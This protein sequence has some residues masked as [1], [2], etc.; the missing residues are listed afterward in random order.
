[1][2]QPNHLPKGPLG[3]IHIPEIKRR[4]LEG[5]LGPINILMCPHTAIT[6]LPAP[7]ETPEIGAASVMVGNLIQGNKLASAKGRELGPANDDPSILLGDKDEFSISNKCQYI[8]EILKWR[9][10]TSPDHNLFTL[11]NHKGIE[12]AS[13]T[14]NQLHKRAERVANL[15]MEK[16]KVNSGDHVALVFPPGIELICAFYACLYVGA[17][18]IPG[19]LFFF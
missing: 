15:L 18:P 19:K 9:A 13:L 1:M 5:T 3:G 8:S 4:F 11:L 16:G 14:C 10:S 12:Q 6:N 7:R 2:V 17:V